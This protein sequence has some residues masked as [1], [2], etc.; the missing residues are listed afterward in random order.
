MG[1]IWTVKFLNSGRIL[2][3]SLITI[4]IMGPPVTRK[5]AWNSSVW[6]YQNKFF[7]C[8]VLLLPFETQLFEKKRL[9]ENKQTMTITY[10]KPTLGIVIWNPVGNIW[11]SAE[12]W[13]LL[14]H[15]FTVHQD[16]GRDRYTRDKFCQALTIGFNAF[17]SC[18]FLKV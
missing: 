13:A 11:R 6:E 1:V 8:F 14:C 16:Y 2:Q 3:H 9:T 17:F 7:V 15:T 12:V 18:Q 5:I 4:S 10:S